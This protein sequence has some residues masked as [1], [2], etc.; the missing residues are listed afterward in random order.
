[1]KKSITLAP[2]N[3]LSDKK[4]PLSPAEKKSLEK[5]W[6]AENRE[7]LQAHNEHF[8]EHGLFGEEYRAF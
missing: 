5:A 4:K 6:L 7:A 1:M 8:E 2:K 3:K